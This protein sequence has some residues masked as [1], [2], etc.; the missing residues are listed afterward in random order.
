M[1]LFTVPKVRKTPLGQRTLSP[2][3]CFRVC[4]HT[5]EFTSRKEDAEPP[6]CRNGLTYRACE[7]M[8]VQAGVQHDWIE[9]TT[10]CPPTSVC[11]VSSVVNSFLFHSFRIFLCVTKYVS[12]QVVVWIPAFAGMTGKDPPLLGRVGRGQYLCLSVRKT[13]PQ[14]FPGVRSFFTLNNKLIKTILQDC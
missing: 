9:F 3:T 11:S 8:A 10:H 1:R 2:W 6:A 7:G 13:I 5:Q 4:C 12:T 14:F